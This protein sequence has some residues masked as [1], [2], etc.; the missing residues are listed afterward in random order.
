MVFGMAINWTLKRQGITSHK[1][2]LMVK[3][4][5]TP[6]HKTAFSPND[7]ENQFHLK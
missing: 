7:D 1:V 3:T 2:K 5:P 4:A 6:L